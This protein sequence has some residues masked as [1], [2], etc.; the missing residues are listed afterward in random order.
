MLSA[1]PQLFASSSGEFSVCSKGRCSPGTRYSSLIQRPRSLS[2]QRSE[3]NGRNRLSFQ[4]T[5]L[6]Q[7]GHFMETELASEYSVQL[8]RLISLASDATRLTK[9]RRLT[10]SILPSRRSAF[11]RTVTLSRVDP[12]IEAISR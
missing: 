8:T 1:N 2:L 9:I 10:N 6:P 12:T 4:S 11:K 7:V 5:G 3:Q